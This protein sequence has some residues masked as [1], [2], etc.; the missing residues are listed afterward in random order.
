M[1]PADSETWSHEGT[2]PQPHDHHAAPS[3][4]DFDNTTQSLPPGTTFDLD[5]TLPDSGF[6]AARIQLMGPNQSGGG[7]IWR[8]C[9]SVHATTD[10]AEAMCHSSGTAAFKKSYLPTYA[11]S[12]G[13]AQLS[14]KVFSSARHISLQDAWITGSTLRL[15]FRNHFGG[16]QTLWVKGSALLW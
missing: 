15:R 14:K 11:K 10:S 9:A 13:D 2:N 12:Q 6:V 8:E 3:Q 4:V 5:V 7:G 1:I 16:S